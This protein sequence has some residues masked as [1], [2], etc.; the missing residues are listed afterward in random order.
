MNY[1]YYCSGD[2]QSY[3]CFDF[4]S[5]FISMYDNPVLKSI[6]TRVLDIVT[7]EDSGNKTSQLCYYMAYKRK[8]YID[9]SMAEDF[10]ESLIF[11]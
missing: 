5:I 8:N 1:V 9:Q 4:I 2:T 10:Y 11:S 3:A 6:H 7:A